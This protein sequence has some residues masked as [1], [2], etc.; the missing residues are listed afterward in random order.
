VDFHAWIE[1]GDRG[2]AQFEGEVTTATT[3]GSICCGESTIAVG[4]YNTL[5]Q[6]SLRLP[7]EASGEGPTRPSGRQRNGRQK[8]EVSAPGVGIVAARALG[9]TVVL[10]GTSMATAHV[11]GLVALLFQLGQRVCRR[12]TAKEIQEALAKSAPRPNPTDLGLSW[13]PQ[14]GNG[15][16]DGVKAIEAL[17][18]TIEDERKGKANVSKPARPRLV[19]RSQPQRITAKALPEAAYRVTKKPTKRPKTSR[20]RKS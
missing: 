6:A 15:P 3:L 2:A 4:A 12:L 7:F 14:L 18:G 9:G 5:E 1:Q 16:V 19:P 17:R 20:R 8:P 11:T 10:S 13:H